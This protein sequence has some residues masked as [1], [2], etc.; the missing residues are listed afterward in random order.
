MKVSIQGV[1]V[2]RPYQVDL[3]P[4]T[5]GSI[6]ID[7]IVSLNANNLDQMVTIQGTLE[8]G[9]DDD[10]AIVSLHLNGEEFIVNVDGN[11]WS[12]SLKASKLIN[13]DEHK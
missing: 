3:I 8:F 6:T 11:R 7:P 4:P 10:L 2:V 9:S 5:V 13:A 12:Y 1:E